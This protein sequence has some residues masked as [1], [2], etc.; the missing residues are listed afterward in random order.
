M[1]ILSFNNIEDEIHVAVLLRL[2]NSIRMFYSA[3]IGSN[4][5]DVFPIL[6]S[7]EI[8]STGKTNFGINPE[9]RI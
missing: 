9:I 7:V 4:R 2:Q 3:R 8:S 1:Q 5:R 6:H